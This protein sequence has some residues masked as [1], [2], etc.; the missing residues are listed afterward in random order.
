MPSPKPEVSGSAAK[1]PLSSAVAMHKY[2]VLREL[3][4]S[5]DG[6]VDGGDY[7]LCWFRC[8]GKGRGCFLA[9]VSVFS[10]VC[11][12]TSTQFTPVY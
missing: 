1:Q 7:S 3:D 10:R 8:L 4:H 5:D 6:G 11:L 2:R 9:A 12:S